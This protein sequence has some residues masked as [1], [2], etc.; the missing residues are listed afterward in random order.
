MS[1]DLPLETIA[2]YVSCSLFS[3]SGKKS[4]TVVDQMINAGLFKF[5]DLLHIGA[6][7]DSARYRPEAAPP[8]VVPS[9]QNAW[10]S[11][12]RERSLPAW[13]ASANKKAAPDAASPIVDEVHRL[14]TAV[15][16]G[17]YVALIATEDRARQEIEAR[18]LEEPALNKT[19][20]LV[21]RKQ[22]HDAFAH[23][24]A[25][26]LW[27]H[28]VHR[29]TMRKPA[30][31][32]LVGS[33]L[34]QAL[35]PLDDQT[36]AYSAAR[37]AVADRLTIGFAP[38]RGRVWVRGAKSWTDFI[39]VVESIT[40]ILSSPPASHA[41][42]DG[43]L[44]SV[45]A[46]PLDNGV[47]V[48]S[49]SAV[50]L[51]DPLMLT[52]D[53]GDAPAHPLVR[54]VLER[55]C[56]TVTA[57]KAPSPPSAALLSDASFGLSIELDSDVIATFDVEVVRRKDVELQLA[58]KRTSVT[59]SNAAVR[60]SVTE[61]GKYMRRRGALSVWYDSGHA[62]TDG[63][64]F[65]TQHRDIQFR[66]WRWTDFGA[67]PLTEEKPTKPSGSFT[68][69]GK[70]VRT[71][72]PDSIGQAEA[73]LFCWLVR[74]PKS[75]LPAGD[76]WLICDDGSHETSDF[77]YFSP[78]TSHVILL[79][80]KGA[81]SGKP[82]RQVSVG[83]YEVVAAQAIKNLR[84]LPP[85][86]LRTRL[87]Q[88]EQTNTS[89]LV[90]K[91]NKAGNWEKGDWTKCMAELRGMHSQKRDVMIVQPSLRRSIYDKYYGKTPKKLPSAEL[92]RLWQLDYLLLAAQA[93]CRAFG[94]EL[95]VLGDGN[96]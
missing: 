1:A 9:D 45:L 96:G 75:C 50:V 21:S 84:W 12:Y 33:R 55:G 14:V 81:S 3:L 11:Y 78:A 52:T 35:N 28:G 91:R 65:G 27:L 26:T 94:A 86:R 67:Y 43:E 20:S 44:S 25:K 71:Y 80:V 34:Q 13:L 82:K 38:G 66:S 72:D 62:L 19:L 59:P 54:E 22:L 40:T 73:S 90:W 4:A 83:D 69:S 53:E 10:A 63:G 88:R 17:D 48:R 51:A 68:P 95:T 76:G 7:P 92:I 5:D 47:S 39:T 77:V 8:L 36:F 89:Q 57:I 79:H 46:Q 42:D 23:R 6:T 58:V 29:P 2:P 18:W 74:E 93:S 37:C 30:S 24:P 61:L 41:G 87:L 70:P 15:F 64:L 31:K 16:R 49:P 32:I 60:E 85:D 56:L